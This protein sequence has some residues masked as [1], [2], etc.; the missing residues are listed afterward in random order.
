[1]KRFLIVL[2]AAMLLLSAGVCSA[3]R[4]APLEKKAKQ[5]V[6]R[7]FYGFENNDEG[8]LEKTVGDMG[9]YISSIDEAQRG[10]FVEAFSKYFYEY[11]DMY[12]YGK[13]F[14]DMFLMGFSQAM[15]ETGQE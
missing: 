8:A 9:E 14:A 1:M 13:A 6:E 12:D 10:E 5:F 11:S 15:A 7:L 4:P 3:K 2:S